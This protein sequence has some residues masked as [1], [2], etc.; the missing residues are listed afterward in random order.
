MAQEPTIPN[1]EQ[2]LRDLLDNLYAVSSNAHETGDFPKFKGLM[3]VITSEPV[4]VSAIHKMKS[5]QGSK[6]PGTDGKNIHDILTKDYHT[7]L[8]M[9]KSMG[10]NY[11]P[12]LIRRVFIPKAGKEELRPLGIPTIADRVFQ[13]C[14]RMVI[15]PIFEAQFFKHSYGFRPMRGTDQAFER[16]KWIIHKTGYHWVI[17]GD[18]KGFFDNV[19]HTILLKRMWHMGIRDRRL[20][21]IIKLMLRAGVMNE[22][23]TSEVGTPQGGII[24]PLLANIY[25]DAFD[26]WLTREWEEK[27]LRYEYTDP[28]NRLRAM[29][30]TNLKPYYLVRYADDWILVTRTKSEAEKL[31][32]KIEKWL[33]SNLKLTL[34]PEKTLITNVRKKRIHFLGYSLKM[35]KGRANKGYTCSAIPNQQRLESKIS[36]LR[37]DIRRLKF[38][39]D[40]ES[41]IVD[42]SKINSKIRGIVQYYQIANRTYNRLKRYAWDVEKLAY[43]VINRWFKVELVPA[44]DTGNLIHVHKD[45]SRKIPTVTYEERKIGLTSLCFCLFTEGNLKNPLE[46]PY[47]EIGRQ[48][49]VKRTAKKPLHVRMDEILMVDEDAHNQKL[50]GYGDRRYNFEYYMNRAYAFNRDKGQC[51][52]CKTT[53]TKSNLHVHH[54]DNKLPIT[55]VNKVSNLACLCKECHGIMHNLSFNLD[56]LP[57]VQRNKIIKYRDVLNK[58]AS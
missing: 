32:H 23:K 31:K 37:K 53:L 48:M 21:T 33:K 46:T 16:T 47:T 41:L 3:E 15:E 58:H 11:N 56:S 2:E 30:S 51:K 20:L 27:K 44:K 8:N 14:I 50:F 22:C 12:K 54:I 9:V 34:S 6:T 26:K 13:E 38:C 35:V 4:I 40:K 19:N 36:E 1:T 52:V 17:E 5:N 28:S 49:Y 7:V 57:R 39:P 10:S 43:R 25:L 45:Y 29:K 55:L 24:S 42:L 18:I